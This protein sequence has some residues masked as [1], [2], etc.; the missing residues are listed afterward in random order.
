[1]RWMP[2]CLLLMTFVL[3]ARA[4]DSI[5]DINKK[6]AE[7]AYVTL[8]PEIP[9]LNGPQS[10]M[11]RRLAGVLAELDGAGM[12]QLRGAVGAPVPA[13]EFGEGAQRVCIVQLFAGASAKSVEIM[14][15]QAGSLAARELAEGAGAELAAPSGMLTGLDEE[16]M[17]AMSPAWSVFR[18]ALDSQPRE[19]GKEI[20]PGAVVELSRPYTA[21]WVRFDKDE[22]SRRFLRG[23]Q[24]SIDGAT[25]PLG[26]NAIWVR[27]PRGYDP[28]RPAGLL[29]WI[30]AGYLGQPPET[31]SAACDEFGLVCV[32]PAGA[33]NDR[34]LGNR[35]Q[36][37]FDAVATACERFHIEPRRMYATGISGGGK[38]SSMLWACF[39][40]VF[41]GAVPIVG[42]AC[43][44][45]MP[46]GNGQFWPGNFDKPEQK[47]W[48]LLRTRRAGVI[49]GNKDFNYEPIHAAMKVFTRDGLA[50]RVYVHQG[51]GHEMPG[52]AGFTE[53][54][55]WVD[56][57]YRTMRSAEE[58][59]AGAALEKL[60]KEWPSLKDDA[61]RKRL[62]EI[63]TLG[64]WTAAAW[65]AV[66]MLKG[67]AADVTAPA[68][69]RTP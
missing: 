25:R 63:T 16:K 21:G 36:L 38:I 31:L 20:E 4:G 27:L 8:A 66:G 39:P 7:K 10:A 60:K 29:V 13:S 49:T 57:P 32:G 33:G 46:I 11:T 47:V 9:I 68:A 55:S 59:K 45:N 50:A 35:C 58:A 69:P 56:E 40:D 64:P 1:M 61:R 48:A 44:E 43:Y 12:R 34:D 22:L 15:S 41:A 62:V 65:E 53:A 24:T 18:G 14:R 26:E 2:A 67:E 54:M 37:I 30:S 17:L 42:L 52:A 5:F 6:P 19:S 23:R 51:M 3:A 28:R